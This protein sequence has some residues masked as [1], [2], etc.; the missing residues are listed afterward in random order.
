MGSRPRLFQK[1]LAIQVIIS[2]SGN[3]PQPNMEVL[4]FRIQVIFCTVTCMLGI[5]AK[6]PHCIQRFHFRHLK[7]RIMECIDL[8]DK[9]QRRFFRLTV[10]PGGVPP[11]T[12]I[13]RT[14]I[15]H[16]TFRNFYAAVW[17]P[18]C[19]LKHMVEITLCGEISSICCFGKSALNDSIPLQQ[20][21]RIFDNIPACFISSADAS[22]SSQNFRISSGPIRAL[23]ILPS[24]L[25]R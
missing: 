1:I 13:V 15:Y 5:N 22:S 9:L 7:E 3:E 25:N 10:K 20:R 4:C 21:Q 18:L 8:F 6:K 23:H 16:L 17:D 19:F 2:V 11:V 14:G 24:P 12:V